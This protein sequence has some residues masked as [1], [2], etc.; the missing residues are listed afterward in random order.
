MHDPH[1]VAEAAFVRQVI[2]PYK[3]LTE[4]RAAPL[5][6]DLERRVR[7]VLDAPRRYAP[8]TPPPP[9]PDPLRIKA[10]HWNIEHGNWYEQI[11]GALLHREELAD[12]DI[13][14][15]NEI[16]FGMARAANRDV[17][18]DLAQALDRYAVWAP[19]FIETTP[20]RDEDPRVAA[21]RM[22]QESLFGLAILSRWPI[23]EVR[24]VEL[25]SP[26][27]VQ[28]DFERMLGRH[29]GLIAT[30]ERP[31]APFVAVSVH[32]EVHRTRTRRAAQVRTLMQALRD[33]RR[34]VL[35][36]GDFNSHTF[37]RGLWHAPLAGA[38]ALLLTP[39]GVLRRRFL[40]PDRGLNREFA[41]D[42]LRDA[43]FEWERFND[44]Q[45]TLNLRFERLDEVNAIPAPLR[46]V[47]SSALRWAER[48]GRMRLDW[49]AGRG[50][51]D[52]RGVTVAGLDGPG[53]ASDHA[54]IVAEF[55]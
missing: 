19:L 13:H 11:E 5:W 36:A 27:D 28:F 39:G 26:E 1:L 6:P 48:R 23:G 50:W 40:R 3:T 33:E 24:I 54:P 37:D 35:L 49:F 47:A 17:T 30:I 15:F 32:L 14:L 46:G 16:D 9:S 8:E 10:V 45:P 18:A 34:P 52:G 31:G 20:G 43:G 29:I 51:R 2:A 44:R 4:L 7:A 41:F 55:A 42:E 53:L 25:P 21:G 38:V 12:A 22:N